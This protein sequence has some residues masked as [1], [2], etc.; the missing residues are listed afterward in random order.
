MAVSL[1]SG[2]NNIPA[3]YRIPEASAVTPQKIDEQPKTVHES[4]VAVD[5]VKEQSTGTQ[6]VQ[7]D[8]AEESTLQKR[9][10]VN[11]SEISMTFHKEE[12]F[13][14]LGSESS[15]MNLDMQKAISDMKKDSILQDYQYFV[16]S[17]ISI[18]PEDGMVFRK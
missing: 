14:Y 6:Q 9:T 17:T 5:A 1:M 11:P 10:S 18:N 3:Y 4:T 13:D 16:G 8:A 7:Q 15:L 2:Y 12:T